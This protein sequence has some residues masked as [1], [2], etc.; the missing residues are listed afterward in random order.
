MSNDEC[1]LTINDFGNLQS[2]IVNH[3][4]EIRNKLKNID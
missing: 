3:H 2:V 1:R 4:S